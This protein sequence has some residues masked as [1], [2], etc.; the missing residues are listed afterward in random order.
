MRR[1]FPLDTAGQRFM[2]ELYTR[3]T[4]TR[5]KWHTKKTKDDDD[6][7][8]PSPSRRSDVFRRRI[9]AA[10]PKPIEALL[11]LKDSDPKPLSRRDQVIH[12]H[13]GE[14]QT[15]SS[16]TTPRDGLLEMMMMIPPEPDVKDR[17]YDGISADGRSGRHMYL[18]S[19]NLLDPD[20]KYRLPVVSSW[21]YGWNLKDV[22]RRETMKNPQFGRKNLVADTFYSRNGV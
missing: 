7:E 5:L 18:K 13:D 6:D 22:V 12:S 8:S 11:R 2:E 3:E 17:L 16:T 9:E 4:G 10:R 1:H 19:R 21:Q 15:R 20:A 14:L